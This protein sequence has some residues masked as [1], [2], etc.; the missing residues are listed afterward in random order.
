M[1]FLAGLT[2]VLLVAMSNI[3]HAASGV[4]AGKVKT[5]L[6]Y[7]GHTGVLVVQENMVDHGGCGRSD[8]YILDEKHDYFNEIYSLILSAHIAS[9][10]LYLSLDGCV[11]G[12]SRIKHVRSTKS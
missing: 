11:Q 3:A 2:M 5:L 1:K 12:I 6:W 4:G 7:E 10:P 8:Y 9:Q